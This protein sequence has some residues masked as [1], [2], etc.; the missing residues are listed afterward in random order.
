MLDRV[1]QCLFDIFTSQF[2]WNTQFFSDGM[3]DSKHAFLQLLK[4]ERFSRVEAIGHM[5][6]ELMRH[7]V[8][9]DEADA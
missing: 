7:W 1:D 9:G 6:V 8:N 4:Q 2:A 3:Q 5:T